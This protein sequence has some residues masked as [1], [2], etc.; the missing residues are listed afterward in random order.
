MRLIDI[1][2]AHPDKKWAYYQLVK[3]PS[4]SYQDFLSLPKRSYQ[5]F[6]ENPSLTVD[7]I[8]ANLDKKW[9]WSSISSEANI[10]IQFAF[11]AI[12]S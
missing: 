4:I 9:D 8:K 5:A 2:K 11:I 12:R 1:V 6:S 7:I 10:T 3:N